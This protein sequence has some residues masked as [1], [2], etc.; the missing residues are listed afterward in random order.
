CKAADEEPLQ[1][2]KPLQHCGFHN[3]I[4]RAEFDR[5]VGYQTPEGFAVG[6]AQQRE[7]QLA[8]AHEPTFWLRK[9]R[10][11]LFEYRVQ[12]MFERRQKESL[13]VAKAVVDA[14][15]AQTGCGLELRDG[16]PRIP[17]AAKCAHGARKHLAFIVRSRSDHSF[18]SAIIK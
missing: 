1:D 17:L 12:V 16:E 4:I 15:G 18:R 2:R 11:A 14:A 7:K 10:D 3:H 6:L 13:L 8:N 9:F 5:R